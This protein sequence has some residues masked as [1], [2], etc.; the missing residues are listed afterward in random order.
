MSLFSTYRIETK[1]KITLTMLVGVTYACTDEFHQ[2]FVQGRSA[3]LRDVCIDGCGVL[4]GIMITLIIIKIYKIKGDKNGR[5]S[6]HNS[7]SL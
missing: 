7:T 6:E 5:F 1:K 2:L 3:E 4:L